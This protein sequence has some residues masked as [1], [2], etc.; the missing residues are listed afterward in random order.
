MYGPCT[1]LSAPKTLAT[2]AAAAGRSPAIA[3]PWR[4]VASPSHTAALTSRSSCLH[5]DGWLI[6]PIAVRGAPPAGLADLRHNCLAGT[7]R[8]TPTL[9]APPA[10]A[11]AGRARPPQCRP[12]PAPP[13]LRPALR[14]AFRAERA[15]G[16]Q[17]RPSRGAMPPAHNLSLWRRL[18][19]AGASHP[20]RGGRVGLAPQTLRWVPLVRRCAGLRPEAPRQSSGWAQVSGVTHGQMLVSFQIS[21]QQ[22]PPPP[23]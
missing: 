22:R 19:N 8:C 16:N 13:P 6:I 1:T 10:C 20:G 17:W 18:A 11:V 5:S 9:H 14:R 2:C 3:A 23:A 4:G 7:R 21:P 12:C 15:G